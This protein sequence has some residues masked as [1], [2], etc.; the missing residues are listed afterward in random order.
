MEGR[1]AP[2][3]GE[4]FKWLRQNPTYE[5]KMPEKNA[6][7]VLNDARSKHKRQMNRKLMEM[8]SNVNMTSGKPLSGTQLNRITNDFE[9]NLF[10]YN[11]K[12]ITGKYTD[13]FN[14]VVQYLDANKT[15]FEWISSGRLTTRHLVLMSEDDF[16]KV[17]TS[18]FIDFIPE[19][20]LFPDI[21]TAIPSQRYKQSSDILSS[22][23][24]DTTA[25]HGKGHQ[26]SGNCRICRS[27]RNESS[28]LDAQ[29]REQ[30]R[31]KAQE[32]TLYYNHKLKRCAPSVCYFCLNPVTDAQRV[33]HREHQFSGKQYDETCYQCK[34]D[35]Y[36]DDV[37]KQLRSRRDEYERSRHEIARNR[38]Q[39]LHELN[40]EVV[41]DDRLFGTGKVSGGAGLLNEVDDSQ[42]AS[43]P[44]ISEPSAPL[45][46]NASPPRD[47]ILNSEPSSSGLL[48]SSPGDAPPPLK[49]VSQ[50]P[51]PPPPALVP[52][53]SQPPMEP[54]GVIWEGNLVVADDRQC[55]VSMLPIQ[56]SVRNLRADMNTQIITKGKLE[57]T[58][59]FDYL[60][61][62]HARRKLGMA[63]VEIEVPGDSRGKKFYVE[64][65]DTLK[66]KRMLGATAQNPAS[67]KEIYIMSLSASEDFP[68]DFGFNVTLSGP[69]HDMLVAII[70]RN[71]P[72][73]SEGANGSSAAPA[74]IN[75][76]PASP[77]RQTQEKAFR[78]E[79]GHYNAS[80]GSQRPADRGLYNEAQNSSFP[81]FR[82]ETNDRNRNGSA[83]ADR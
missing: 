71:R 55:R 72:P 22:L 69:R 46:L 62:I 33:A 21:P 24:A 73:D 36:E 11:G 74:I 27:R 44:L 66:T 2:N 64:Y 30:L 49:R 50:A 43:E 53:I 25:E 60:K 9:L 32:K 79:N 28:I 26:Y 17:G 4:L 23:A 48:G 59:A 29:E 51:S 39:V 70:I 58:Q 42:P 8:N 75:R 57:R 54:A 83:P 14:R 65:F 12:D 38:V 40:E 63:V 13:C 20:D 81:Y 18:Q 77:P 15:L 78:R 56:G 47:S 76:R 3:I 19:S 5:I 80:S 41:E 6:A 34:L 1:R 7:E 67:I 10:H 52:V 61:K 68:S 45:G 31:I 16:K 82:E 35:D 37:S